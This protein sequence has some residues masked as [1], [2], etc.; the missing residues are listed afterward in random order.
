VT[1]A[2]L[3]DLE[4]LLARYLGSLPVTAPEFA[5]GTHLARGVRQ[6]RQHAQVEQDVRCAWCGAQLGIADACCARG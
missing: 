4:R 5:L 6:A 2:E 1:Y 3:R